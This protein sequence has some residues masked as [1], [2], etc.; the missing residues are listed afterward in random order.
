MLRM[1]VGI[2]EAM[3]RDR[4]TSPL[5]Y[6]VAVPPDCEY[7]T[8]AVEIGRRTRGTEVAILNGTQLKR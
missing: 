1:R 8:E 6:G 5:C 2:K 7:G 4:P 3:I